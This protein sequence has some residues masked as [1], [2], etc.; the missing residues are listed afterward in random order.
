MENKNLFQDITAYWLN[1]QNSTMEKKIQ[2]VAVSVQ[3]ILIAENPFCPFAPPEYL[4]TKSLSL[5]S[6]LFYPN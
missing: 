3:L 4:K 6:I 2:R 1:L 5:L